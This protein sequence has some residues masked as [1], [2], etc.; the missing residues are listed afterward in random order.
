MKRIGFFIIMTLFGFLPLSAQHINFG[1]STI[2][3]LITCDPGEEI[4]A[5]F[6]HTAIRVRGTE[7][8]D[9]VFN[10]GLFDFRTKNFYWKFLRGHTDYMLGVS[11]TEDFLYE[12]YVRNSTVYEQ[13]LNLN[14][15]E[16]QKLIHLLNVNYEPKNRTYR[17]NFVYDNCA[18]RPQDIIQEA[19]S[20]VIVD[21]VVVSDETFREII[22]KYLSKDAWADFGIN[23]IFGVDADQQAGE[24]GHTFIPDNL[25][26]YFQRAKI[27]SYDDSEERKLV[28]KT[29]VLVQATPHQGKGTSWLVQPF[30]IASLWFLA[31]LML[32]FFKESKSKIYRIF[33]T[34]LYF[35]TGI[36][37]LLIM[38]FSFFSVHPLVPNNINILWLNPLSVLIAFLLWH[39][40]ARKFLFFYNIF[41]LLLIIIYIIVSVFFV[42][43]IV[44]AT[45]PLL[46]LLLLRTLRREERLLHIL[47]TPTSDGLKWK[48]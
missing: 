20:G 28:S 33:D 47:L 41:Y 6:G 24:Q 39:N 12:Y 2:I 22:S 15:E 27:R 8:L 5:K 11:R 38:A 36:A 44:P 34:I 19:L 40:G 14:M 4:Y 37:G 45:V 18:T 43:S 25:K 3:S 23:L 26:N 16:K 9:V 17:Y 1:D 42:H 21:D 48:K 46:A 32:T 10:Y 35:S 13:V 7:G 30:T 29:E 31:G